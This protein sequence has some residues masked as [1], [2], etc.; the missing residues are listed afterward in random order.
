MHVRI[1][2]ACAALG[3]A[4][5]LS[6]Q[7]L[8]GPPTDVVARFYAEPASE[9]DEAQRHHFTDPLRR[10][11]DLNDQIR[12]TG[13]VGCIDFS[14]VVSGQDSDDE[15]VARTVQFSEQVAGES[16]TVVASFTNFGWPVEVEWNLRRGEGGWKI[17]DVASTADGWRLSEFDC[18]P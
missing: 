2:S 3:I 16:A 18:T 6:T 7:A 8:A 17:A 9:F 15:E 1:T 13:D 14:F 11:L 12:D 5:S 10:Q 4:V